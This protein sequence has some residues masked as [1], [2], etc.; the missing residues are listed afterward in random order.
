MTMANRATPA[1]PVMCPGCPW[2]RSNH[3]KRHP[4]GFYRKDNLRRLWNQ[5][6]RG[7]AQQSCHLT[8]ASHPDHVAAGAPEN[9][10]PRECTGSIVL[11]IRELDKIKAIAGGPDAEITPE[12]VNEY[13]AGNRRGLTWDGLV[14][15]MLQRIQMANQRLYG[16]PP[17][18][19]LPRELVE[20]HDLIAGP[21]QA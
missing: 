11:V 17:I 9:A 7:Q 19:D 14:Y 1:T 21:P 5:I 2:R 20:D 15:W 13:L 6:R 12:H 16:E 10:T 3:G 18:P 8:D 4:G